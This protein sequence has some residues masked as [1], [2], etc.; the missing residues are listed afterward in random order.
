MNSYYNLKH[1]SKQL[2]RNSEKTSL[3]KRLRLRA[4][5]TS[6]PI[7]LEGCDG[8]VSFMNA[9]TSNKFENGY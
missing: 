8:I 2:Q 9:F 4:R 3:A 1:L 7:I 5:H 6:F